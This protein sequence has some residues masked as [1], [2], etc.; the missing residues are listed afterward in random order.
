MLEN[1]GRTTRRVGG[2]GA[3]RDEVEEGKDEPAQQKGC[4]DASPDAVIDVKDVS[5]A[6][7]R[8]TYSHL[9]VWITHTLLVFDLNYS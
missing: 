9:L 7:A 2:L 5:F 4:S 6:H 1:L 8:A 3:A